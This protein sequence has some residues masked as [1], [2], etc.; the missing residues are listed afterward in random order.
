MPSQSFRETMR[1]FSFS[2]EHILSDTS[3]GPGTT[4]TDSG[5]TETP[6]K[7]VEKSSPLGLTPI[8]SAVLNCLQSQLALR[9]RGSPC[10]ASSCSTACQSLCEPEETRYKDTAL[11]DRSPTSKHDELPQRGG[12]QDGRSHHPGGQ[13]LHCGLEVRADSEADHPTNHSQVPDRSEF[14]PHHHH[15][16]LLPPFT[17]PAA[18][19]KLKLDESARTDCHQHLSS[20]LSK[21]AGGSILPF[22]LNGECKRSRRF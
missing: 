21:T 7:K 15:L 1:P 22:I 19:A 18:L 6:K 10:S 16:P 17:E 14:F 12:A 2:I 13:S 8:Y 9:T 20:F 3:S 11:G 5:I 4:H